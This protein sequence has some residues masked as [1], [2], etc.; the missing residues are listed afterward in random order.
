MSGHRTTDERLLRSGID[1]AT[2]ANGTPVC[3]PTADVTVPLPPLPLVA[4]RLAASAARYPHTMW[5]P[6]YIYNKA[7]QQTKDTPRKGST[8]FSQRAKIVVKGT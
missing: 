4:V 1:D 8:I 6:P 5:L 7:T 3:L 2:S